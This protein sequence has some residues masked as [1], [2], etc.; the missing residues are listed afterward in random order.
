VVGWWLFKPS[1]TCLFDQPSCPGHKP[2]D[3]TEERSRNKSGSFKI[4][5]EARDL[6]PKQTVKLPISHRR[7]SYNIQILTTQKGICFQLIKMC[8][9]CSRFRMAWRKVYIVMSYVFKAKIRFR[10]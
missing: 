9:R 7:K 10:S 5:S 1:D 3:M 8:K 6:P 2:R 4:N